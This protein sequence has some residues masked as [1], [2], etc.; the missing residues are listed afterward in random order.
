MFGEMGENRKQERKAKWA[1]RKLD[2]I[3]DEDIL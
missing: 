3:Q 1:D 2:F